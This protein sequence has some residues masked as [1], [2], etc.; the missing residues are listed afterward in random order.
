MSALAHPATSVSSSLRTARPSADRPSVLFWQNMPSHHQ[1]GTL[2][3]FAESW[4]A[5]VTGVWC[6]DISAER[7]SHGWST[8]RHEAV[9]DRFL[10]STGWEREVDALVDQNLDAIH[11]FSGIGPYPAVTRAAHRLASRATAPRMGLIVEPCEM[12]GWKKWLRLGL[13]V[14]RYWNFRGSISAV[15]AMGQQGV[16]FYRT[17]GFRSDCIY[18]YLYQSDAGTVET[19]AF[20]STRWDELD[21]SVPVRLAYVGQLTHRKGVDT[22]LNALGRI[23]DLN[24]TLDIYGD[25]PE[26]AALQSLASQRGI[27]GRINFHGFKPSATITAQLRKAHVSVIPSRFDG[28]GMATNEAIQAGL[29]TI[30]SDRASSSVLVE[31]SRAGAVFRTEDD[32]ALADA[33]ARRIRDRRMLSVERSRA[34]DFSY[35]LESSYTGRYLRRSIEHA[36]LGIGT[37]PV[38][39][40]SSASVESADTMLGYF[41]GVSPAAALRD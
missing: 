39:P 11:I 23:S 12:R 34:V 40:W 37:R 28:W 22:L 20:D 21:P 14:K 9:R 4:G 27:G 30:V 8:A 15:F 1:M 19:E 25:G 3:A 5:P 29:C 35:R 41:G 17:V 26:R 16:D 18:P 36:F 33:L 32:S 6:S 24:W 31:A 2:G 13:S 38:A 7:K 10:P